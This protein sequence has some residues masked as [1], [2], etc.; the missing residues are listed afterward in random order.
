MGILSNNSKINQKCIDLC[1]Q[2]AQACYECFRACLDE[3]DVQARKNCIALLVECAQICQM[4]AANMAMN[5]QFT[6][7]LCNIC[8]LV[9]EKCAQECSM[10]N[11]E[12][13]TKCAQICRDCAT[14]CKNMA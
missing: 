2:C 7:E 5:G 10:F 14:E 13:C 6:K 11:D 1:N 4:A 12:H 3:S 9:C 8:T